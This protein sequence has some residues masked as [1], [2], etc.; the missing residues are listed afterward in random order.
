AIFIAGVVLDGFDIGVGCLSLVAPKNLKPNMLAMLKPWRD[1]NEFWFFLGLG[2]F[3]AAFPYAWGQ[4][5]GRLYFPLALLS[6]GV[7]LRSVCFEFRLRSTAKSKSMW[8]F[9]F[10]VGAV[11]TAFS[12]GYILARII[13]GYESS[14]GY[15]SF[16]VLIGVCAIAAYS[17]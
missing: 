3:A 8:Q 1:A 10:G 16:A 2:L 14:I 6:L 7:I 9:G 17:L 5:I 12:H 15:V 4:T 13:V 11:I